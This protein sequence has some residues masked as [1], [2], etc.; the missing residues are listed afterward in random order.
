MAT[1]TSTTFH[2]FEADSITGDKVSMSDFAGKVVLVINTA[3]E[4]GFTPQYEGLQKLYKKYKDQGFVVLGFPCNQFGGQEPGDEDEIQQNCLANYSISFPV[5]SKVNVNGKDAHPLFKYLK[6]K[7]PGFLGRRI[8]WNFTKFLI[9][10]E[11]NPVERY[12]TTTTPESI[13]R[14]IARLLKTDS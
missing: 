1:N 10:R 5:F 8:K 2:D 7:L 4:C 3:S 13:E 14:D 6:K 12:A 9:D 11:G